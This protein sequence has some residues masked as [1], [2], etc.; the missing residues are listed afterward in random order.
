MISRLAA[1]LALAAI[2]DL[3]A[4]GPAPA[5]E[6]R[7]NIL[8]I[9]VDD[10]NDWIGVLGGHPQA[11][12]PALDRLAAQ[13]TVF[14]NAH[15]QAPICHPSRVSFMTGTLPSTTGLYSMGPMDFRRDCPALRDPAATPTLPE[16]FAARGYRTIGVGKI[17]HNSS[18]TDMFQ[19]YGPRGDW[20]PFPPDGKKLVDAPGGSLWDWGRFPAR[21]EDTVDRAMADWAAA[22]LAEP[23]DKPFFLAVGFFR[24]HAPMYAPP[25]W[26]ELQGDAVRIQL[27]PHLATDRADLGPFAQALSYAATSPR[28]TFFETGSRWR[29]AVQAYL[30]CLS[31]VDA[32][33]GRLLAALERSQHAR[34]TIVVLLGDNGISLGEKSRWGKRSLWERDTRVPL[35]VSAPGLPAGG[36]CAE[37]AGLV[38]VYPTLLELCGYSPGPRLEGRSLVP[39]LRDPAAPRAPTL[40]TFFA[41]NHA[42][43]SRDHRY[44][45]YADGSEELYDHRRDPHE[46]HNLAGRDENRA[47]IS[48]LARFLPIVNTVPLRGSTGLG[49]DPRHLDWFGGVP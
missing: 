1:I 47:V 4:A 32:Q 10:L 35:I 7:P 21:D 16:Y 14:A 36:R 9:T 25:P 22:R 49:V 44:I 37:P 42:V 13:G 33:I 15:C 48:N 19:E 30:A 18:A 12:T 43:R 31:F 46:W 23:A 38:D 34:R 29:E 28:H 5:L 27:P 8:L 11:K 20:G 17:F 45:R 26:W 39:Q 2:P 41:G 6:T 40:T 24:P 3:A